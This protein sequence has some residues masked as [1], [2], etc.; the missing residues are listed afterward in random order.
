LCIFV[1]NYISAETIALQRAIPDDSAE[2][3]VSCSAARQ[4]PLHNCMTAVLQGKCLYLYDY[5]CM[6]A[7]LQGNYARIIIH[8]KTLLLQLCSAANSA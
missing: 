5:A 6:T 4:K 3:I 2:T 1:R 7:A 8:I